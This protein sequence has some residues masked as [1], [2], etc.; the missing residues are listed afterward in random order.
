MNLDAI[1]K[2]VSEWNKDLFVWINSGTSN[3]VFDFIMPL[4]RD[5][6]IWIPVYVFFVA[7]FICNY[8]KQSIY[9]ILFAIL[10]FIISDQLSA[11]ILKPLFLHPRPCS[12][13]TMAA[14]V[15]LLIPCGNGY[16]FPSSHATNHFAFSFFLISL[17]ADKIR[18]LKPAVIIWASL[19][20]YAQV[21]VGVH[22]PIDVIC[23]GLIGL[24]IGNLT[25]FL[26]KLT[27]NLDED[28]IQ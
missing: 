25:G 5:P 3:P 11:H 6:N 17:F 7:F 16:S 23:G 19:V 2:T 12:D 24:L 20:C 14:R 26:C 1:A 10:T 28:L 22:F 8:R 4:L 9:I 21:Y 15:R 27:V 13:V 18:W